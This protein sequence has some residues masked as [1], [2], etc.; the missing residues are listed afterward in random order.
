MRDQNSKI[1][2]GENRLFFSEICLSFSNTETIESVV[3]CSAIG[4][5]QRLEAYVV[6]KTVLFVEI[7]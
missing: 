7:S 3:N 5:L 2:N 4:S 6:K 1:L